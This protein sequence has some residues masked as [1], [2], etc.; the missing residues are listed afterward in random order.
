MYKWELENLKHYVIVQ[1]V[2]SLKTLKNY[3]PYGCNETHLKTFVNAMVGNVEVYLYN[4][5]NNVRNDLTSK[6]RTRTNEIIYYEIIRKVKAMYINSLSR[7]PIHY[8]FYF[9]EQGDYYPPLKFYMWGSVFKLHDEKISITWDIG[10]CYNNLFVSSL[11]RKEQL[12]SY[13]D[14]YERFIASKYEDDNYLVELNGIKKGYNDG[15][16]DLIATKKDK[17]ALVQCKNWSLSNNYKI[18]QKDLRAFVGDC[19]LYMKDQDLNGKSI[20][21]H[22]IVSHNDILTKSAQIFLNENKFLK[23]KCVPFERNTV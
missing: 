1:K 6:F 10:V 21:F 2:E 14:E 4:P 22:F 11:E 17:V 12:K 5:E 9:E 15:G 20:S 7:P 19:Y 16:L 23:F 18:N 3:V 13:G 8:N